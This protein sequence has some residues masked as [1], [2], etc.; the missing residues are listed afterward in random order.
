[1]PAKN[2]KSEPKKINKSVIVK[3]AFN[4]LLEEGLKKISIR[5]IAERLEIK[6]SSI[7][8]HVKNKNE[9]LELLAEEICKEI[10]LPDEELALEE[11]ILQISYEFRR[12]LLKYRDSAYVLVE[13]AP[14]TPYRL[15]LIKKIGGLLHQLG[16]ESEDIFSASWMLNNYIT[17]FVLE[18]YRFNDIPMDDPDSLTFL[19]HLPFDPSA[20]KME[21]EFQF[22]L[23][24]LLE[25]FKSKIK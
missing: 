6:G 7:Y 13:T 15:E 14:T 23:E 22:G 8:W 20:M 24:V 21:N 9:L 5:K 4:V 10:C 18:E 19:E 12:V 25:G 17:S 3:V 1:M 2:E 16:L 11:Q